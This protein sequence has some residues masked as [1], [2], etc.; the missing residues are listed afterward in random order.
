VSLL[1]SEKGRGSKK[2]RVGQKSAQSIV[3]GSLKKRHYQSLQNSKP[4]SDWGEAL[5]Q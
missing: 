4:G 2:Q 3:Q 5:F 1:S